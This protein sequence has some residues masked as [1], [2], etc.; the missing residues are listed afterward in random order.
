MPTLQ[1]AECSVSYKMCLVSF[2]KFLIFIYNLRNKPK[3]LYSND[4]GNGFVDIGEQ[5][6]C[7]VDIWSPACIKCCDPKTCMFLTNATCSVGECCD[8]LV[9]DLLFY[10]LTAYRLYPLSKIGVGPP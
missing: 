3:S 5:C 2:C 10:F 9:R 6:D 8:T 7:G 4:C 1:Y